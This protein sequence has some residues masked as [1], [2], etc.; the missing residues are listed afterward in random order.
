MSADMHQASGALAALS[1]EP[2]SASNKGCGSKRT[3]EDMVLRGFSLPGV[4]DCRRR[5]DVLGRRRICVE[6]DYFNSK[7]TVTWTL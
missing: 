4:E 6:E 2:P 3:P 1:S 5:S 7:V